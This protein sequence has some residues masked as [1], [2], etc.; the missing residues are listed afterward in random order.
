MISRLVI[1][2][3]AA[4]ALALAGC[5]TPAPRHAAAPSASATVSQA[6]GIPGPAPV[7]AI[8]CERFRVLNTAQVKA[9]P[10]STNRAA[11]RRYGMALML[12]SKPLVRSRSGRDRALA[13]EI[14]LAGGEAMALG[15]GYMPHGVQAAYAR[16]TQALDI[17]G[18]DCAARGY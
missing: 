3:P 5:G 7:A 12:T 4:A 1:A 9:D 13:Q 18:R 16:A 10:G 15:D 17:A 11:Q 14:Q 8:V 2:L 6:A